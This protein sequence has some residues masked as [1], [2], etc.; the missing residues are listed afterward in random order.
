MNI[1][2]H[3]CKDI[4]IGNTAN[5]LDQ[6]L[7]KDLPSPLPNY[8][9]F[10]MAI[11]GSSGSGKTTLMYSI[12][13]KRKKKG[14]RQ[15]YRGVFDHIYIVSPTLGNK[16]M[17][18][19]EFAKLP[20]HQIHR[21]LKLETLAELSDTFDKNREE[22][23]HSVLILDDVG[24]QLRKSQAIEK[25]LVQLCQ[26]RRHLFLSVIFIIQK[27]KDLPTGIRN[28]LSH[29][30]FFRPKNNP[31]KEAIMME[32]FPF[33]KNE[34]ESIFDYVYEKD[35]DKD[36]YSFLFV[37]MSLKKSSKYQYYKCFNHLELSPKE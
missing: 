12:M 30:A 26:N 8:S 36:R 7:H 2:E 29:A 27:W 35:E 16:S 13:T 34:T 33:K 10:N 28:N 15:S 31:E 25:K 5:N 23:E 32:L 18:K 14:K 37:D 9:G 17:K 11:A 22:D 24:S 19:D 21:E 4:E 3:I 1:R 20:Q 6:Q